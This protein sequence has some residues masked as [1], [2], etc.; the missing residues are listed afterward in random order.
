LSCREHI[1]IIDCTIEG[2][3]KIAW[4]VLSGSQ[5]DVEKCNNA[6]KKK[7]KE[8]RLSV[9]KS[10][11]CFLFLFSKLCVVGLYGWTFLKMKCNF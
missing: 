6:R 4:W 10:H 9:M 11:R 5:L 8:E 2:T 3:T 7:A 1:W